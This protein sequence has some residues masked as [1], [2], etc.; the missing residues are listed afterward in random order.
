MLC[1]GWAT[2]CTL[3][4]DE[5]TVLVLAAIGAGNLKHVAFGARVRWPS[6]DLVIAGDDDRLTR[7]NPGA[8]KARAAATASHALLALLS[9]ATRTDPLA[10]I[11]IDPPATLEQ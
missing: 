11:K 5:P 6:V 4:K 10:D 3:A 8:T 9:M 1:G 2:G 7:D